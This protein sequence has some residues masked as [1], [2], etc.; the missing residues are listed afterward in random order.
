MI[1]YLQSVKMKVADGKRAANKPKQ[2]AMNLS[3]ACAAS[4]KTIQNYTKRLKFNG[5]QGY[6]PNFV[7]T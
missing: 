7:E 5:R 3:R 2:L 4:V 1:V 6:A